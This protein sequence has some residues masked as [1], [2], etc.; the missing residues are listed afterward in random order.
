MLATLSCLSFFSFFP[1]SL[2]KSLVRS[3]YRPLGL[4]SYKAIPRCTTPFFFFLRRVDVATP[5]TRRTISI[6]LV[7]FFSSFCCGMKKSFEFWA[8][9]AGHFFILSLQSPNLGRHWAVLF[10]LFSLPFG[11]EVT[12]SG[13]G[14][15]FP[16]K[17][18]RFC[19]GRASAPPSPLFFVSLNGDASSSPFFSNPLS[20]LSL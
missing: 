11:G 9:A 7:F 15:L 20:P 10:I 12:T 4:D 1:P 6:I 5:G 3:N 13:N 17:Q 19:C 8:L 14:S 2:W 18:A 16:F